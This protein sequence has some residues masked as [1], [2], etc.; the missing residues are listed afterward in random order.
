MDSADR[1][2]IIDDYVKTLFWRVYG[3]GRYIVISTFS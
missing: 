3:G 1:V 2:N